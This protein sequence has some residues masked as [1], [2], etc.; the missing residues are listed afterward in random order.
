MRERKQ[1]TEEVIGTFLEGHDPMERI[2]G[3]EYKYTDDKIKVL[4]RDANDR[5]KAS[6]ASCARGVRALY[7]TLY[8]YFNVLGVSA[9]FS[10][11]LFSAALRLNC[12]LLNGESL[13]FSFSSSSSL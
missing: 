5:K 13:M 2:V 10:T 8:K 12:T 6:R 4:Y 1:I 3:L 11:S 9:R 7:G